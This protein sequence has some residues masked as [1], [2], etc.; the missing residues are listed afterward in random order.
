VECGAQIAPRS[1]LSRLCI[2]LLVLNEGR[3]VSGTLTAAPVLG[4]RPGRADLVLT[5][6]VPKPRNS[7]RSRLTNAASISSKMALTTFFTSLLN[8]C[9]FCAATR[10]TNIDLI[11]RSLH[12][13]GRVARGG[14]GR[15]APPRPRTFARANAARS[16]QRVTGRRCGIWR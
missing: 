16:R 13:R 15:Q 1:A 7:T 9:G 2:S 4:F 8:R 12:Q 11:M 6:K 3:R 10:R 5:V 14:F